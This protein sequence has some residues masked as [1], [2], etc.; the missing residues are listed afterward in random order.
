MRR[1]ILVTA[2][3]VMIC[4]TSA[5]AE[6]L[7]IRY[8]PPPL[9]QA[10]P[11]SPSQSPQP[12][13]RPAIANAQ[14]RLEEE[15]ETLEAQRQIKK[16][17]LKMAELDVSEAKDDLE[18]TTRKE[19]IQ[20]AKHDLDKAKAQL[21][22]KA[23]ELKE[24]EVK[25][26]HVRK[27]LDETKACIQLRDKA[28]E[29]ELAGAA[30]G[31]VGFGGIP[32]LAGLAQIQPPDTSTSSGTG[33]RIAVFNMAA[34]MKDFNKAKYKV[35]QLNEERKK[36]SME[37]VEQKTRLVQ[38]QQEISNEKDPTKKDELMVEQ[39][40][41]ARQM[42]DSERAINKQLNEKASAII[43]ELYD[44]I[45][46]A[47]DKLSEKRGFDIVFCYPDAT[48]SMEAKSA[49]VKE[50]KLKPPAAQPFVV[51]KHVDLTDEM[52]DELNTRHSAPP[53]PQTIIP[54]LHQPPPAITPRPNP[55][56]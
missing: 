49:Y 26:K 33:T 47:A 30:M 32:L 14:T 44:D 4:M 17:H 51:A 48:T 52:L 5:L 1:F 19:E 38:L 22:I 8:V 46:A 41:T 40:N 29:L 24:V 43:A 12:S 28:K 20:E 39:R 31:V 18:K 37:L 7:N 2:L 53:V 50:L 42:E 54:G 45:K 6:N 34:V 25:I 11:T 16:G 9:P 55:I 56:K 13:S 10:L 21:E 27:R 3:L 35:Y 36:L 23:G 15:L